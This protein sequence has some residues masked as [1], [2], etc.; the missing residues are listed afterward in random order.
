MTIHLSVSTILA[1]FQFCSDSTLVQCFQN[2]SPEVERR[3]STWLQ[4]ALA[5]D[6]HAVNDVDLLLY[7]WVTGFGTHLTALYS[8]EPV[9]RISIPSNTQE[10]AQ[11]VKL[12]QIYLNII[13]IINTILILIYN[14]NIFSH[15]GPPHINTDILLLHLQYGFFRALLACHGV[16]DHCFGWQRTVREGETASLWWNTHS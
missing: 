3:R 12:V 2:R 4:G 15:W 10:L 5:P 13:N 7:P 6:A 9:K 8:L 11:L 14:N 16:I 1:F